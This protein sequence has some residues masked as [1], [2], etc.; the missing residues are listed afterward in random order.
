MTVKER[1]PSTTANPIPP[2]ADAPSMPLTER[3]RMIAERAYYRWQAR[4]APHGS[5]QQDWFE[6]ERDL[7][8]TAR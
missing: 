5:D 8:R 6:A 1:V 3:E 2:Q 7:N 4:G